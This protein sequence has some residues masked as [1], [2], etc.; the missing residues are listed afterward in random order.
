VSSSSKDESSSM[1]S[2]LFAT[3]SERM[4]AGEEDGEYGEGAATD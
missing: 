1:M 2:E 3:T 4:G